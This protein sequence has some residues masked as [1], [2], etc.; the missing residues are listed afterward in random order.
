MRTVV[1]SRDCVAVDLLFSVAGL[2]DTVAPLAQA[3]G[4]RQAVTSLRRGRGQPAPST[5]LVIVDLIAQHNEQPHEEL[6]GNGD[7]G[8]GTPAAMHEREVGAL[9]IGIHARGMGGGLAKGEAEQRAALLGDVAEVMFIGGG[10]RK[11]TRLN[12]SYANIS[13][14]VFCLKKKNRPQADPTGSC[15]RLSARLRESFRKRRGA[16]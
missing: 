7:F 9:E 13:Y 6:A 2:A 3:G 1:G 4:S 15:Q 10:D 8:F 11:S 5:E 14:A 16:P 12:S